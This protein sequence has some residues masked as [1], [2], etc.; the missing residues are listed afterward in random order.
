M[1]KGECNCGVVQFEIDADLSEVFVCHCS[2]CRKS[3]GSNGIAVVVVPNDRLRW[4]QGED[5]IVMWSKP[6]FRLADLV[7]Q[8]LRLSG[9]RPE[10]PSKNVRA[11][12]F[13]YPGR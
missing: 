13:P 12:R 1:A 2:I 8:G 3:T 6:N 10:R 4:V 11:S 7:L 9:A 5:H